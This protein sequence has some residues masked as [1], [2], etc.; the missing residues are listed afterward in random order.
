MG[1]GLS[2][3]VDGIAIVSSPQLPVSVAAEPDV[4][5]RQ[6]QQ[7]ISRSQVAPVS[8]DGGAE[9]V[10]LPSCRGGCD[11]ESS[12]SPP[13]SAPVAPVAEYCLGLA[14][15]E[16]VVP[17]SCRP[18]D[19]WDWVPLPGAAAVAEAI[20][21]TE[22]AS[23]LNVG[24]SLVTI[25]LILK[26]DICSIRRPEF[27]R[28]LQLAIAEARRW[29]AVDGR[30]DVRP[31]DIASGRDMHRA[32]RSSSEAETLISRL[33]AENPGVR[34]VVRGHDQ[35]YH[36]LF[37]VAKAD[38]GKRLISD[39]RTVNEHFARPPPFSHPTIAQV[40]CSGHKFGTK[41]DFRSAF[42]QPEVSA[43]L[44]RA[45]C[46]MAGEASL[47]T[48]TGLPMGWS[49]SPWLFDVICRPLDLL[50]AALGV[51]SV[52][53]VDD[54]AILAD[55]PAQLSVHLTVVAC[56]C[57]LTG[58][59]ISLKKTYV[60]AARSFVFLG[61]RTDLTS[62]SVSWAS[63]KRLKVHAACRAILD[64]H[65]VTREELECL[66]GRLS[67]L[68]QSMPLCRVFLRPFYRLSSAINTTFSHEELAEL[69]CCAAFWVSP[70]GDQI[71]SRWWPLQS[72]GRPRW[73]GRTDASG[74]GLGWG[75]IACPDGTELSGGSVP[76]APS[77]ATAG[78]AVR[79]AAALLALVAFLADPRRPGP[80][81][82]SGDCLDFELDALVTVCSVNR[83]SA[84]ASDLVDVLSDVARAILALPPVVLRLRWIPRALNTEADTRSRLV[85]P[86]DSRLTDEAYAALCLWAGFAPVIDLFA[87]ATN[88]RTSRFYSL[89]ATASAEGLDGLSAPLADRAYAYPP[90]GIAH[91]VLRQLQR[92]GDAGLRFLAVLP[93]DIVRVRPPSCPHVVHVFDALAP[94]VVPPPYCVLSGRASAK[95]LCA[96]ATSL[97][98]AQ[99]T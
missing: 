99:P 3:A 74:V 21:L 66:T 9:E 72:S 18:D 58:W 76:I 19:D 48:Y 79:E 17:G 13:S 33:I 15:S 73:T 32:R 6:L 60:C 93:Y 64:G 11:E 98:R 78:S 20:R 40:A 69:R 14:P 31:L 26:S 50:L 41:L 87:T 36:R 91:L 65:I 85:G 28:P 84:K 34:P 24:A 49:W 92:H 5:S 95:Q 67:F 96:V 97:L 47:A 55:T 62:A 8:K 12:R 30:I 2:V 94:I 43:D 56:I 25:E 7:H 22:K 51:S 88:A 42:Y 37:C 77:M 71:A 63:T 70:A 80:P 83:G 53:Y 82:R 75:R 4:R 46:F 59:V 10:S 61:V 35:W 86:A 39:L 54:L 52:R 23:Q 29:L 81:I 90:F 89:L 45:F 68:L 16:A 1:L 38:G 57:S 27:L 44:S